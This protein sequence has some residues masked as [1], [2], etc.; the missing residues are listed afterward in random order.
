M[1]N[2]ITG[3]ITN[4][5]SWKETFDLLNDTQMLLCE[6]V[7]KIEILLETTRHNELMPV[8]LSYQFVELFVS[9]DEIINEYEVSEIRNVCF[10]AKPNF[11]LSKFIARITIVT[12]HNHFS[13]TFWM[14]CKRITK[15]DSK[16]DKKTGQ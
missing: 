15:Q 3:D 12:T 14:P 5:L 13:S 16:Q 2:F 9:F 8:L 10:L 7:Y 4:M 1:F 6:A 11:Y